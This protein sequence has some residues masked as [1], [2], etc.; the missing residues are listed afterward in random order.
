[1]A[2]RDRVT[3]VMNRTLTVLVALAVLAGA[4]VP[5]VA[6]AQPATQANGA[7]DPL[8]AQTQM[9]NST[10]ATVS[11]GAMLAG[12]I[13]A[14]QAEIRGA[15]DHRAF[16]LQIAAA[17]SNQTRARILA[18]HQ[19]RLQ[20]RL[21][22]VQ[23]RLRTMEHARENGSISEARYQV[24][25]T[26]AATEANQ[27]RNMANTSAQVANGLPAEILEANGVNVTAIQ[28]LREH[29][30]DMTGPEVAQLARQIAGK[31]TGHPLGPPDGIPGG[32][33]DGMPGGPDGTPGDGHGNGGQG[34]QGQGGAGSGS[35]GGSTGMNMSNMTQTT[36]A[37]QG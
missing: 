16:G 37:T 18:Q 21:D 24:Q 22:G 15:V 2:H 26:K 23:E 5:A 10:N 27:I 30:R 31:Q 9:N 19:E 12:S 11:P 6:I 3:L 8:Q 36:T 25:A 14:Q 29:A 17:E 28:Q 32:P 20:E 1:M 35:G 33:M 13:G 34:G 4:M 7:E